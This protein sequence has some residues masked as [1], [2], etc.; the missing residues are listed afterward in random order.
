MDLE[1]KVTG[2]LLAGGLARRMNNQD[3]GLVLFRGRPLVEYGIAAMEKTADYTIINA[4]RNLDQYRQ[5]GLP[6][7]PDR[8]N[9]FDGPLAGILTAMLHAQSGVLLTMPCDA[10][11][12]KTEHLQILLTMLMNSKKADAAVACDRERLHPVFL[13]VKA[14]LRDDLKAYLASGNRKV[15]TWLENQ[16]SVKAVFDDFKIFTNINTLKELA[17]QQAECD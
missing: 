10:P 15:E 7:V 13:A 8:N 6:V 1:T 5:F 4:N 9:D 3:K 12:F 2:V 14:N 16:D 11:F 17:E